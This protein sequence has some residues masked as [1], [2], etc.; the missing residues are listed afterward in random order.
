MIFTEGHNHVVQSLNG[1]YKVLRMPYACVFLCVCVYHVYVRVVGRYYIGSGN[2]S[3]V[4]YPLT[5]MMAVVEVYRGPIRI[6]GHS[7][8]RSLLL[9]DK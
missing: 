9:L 2:N 7:S 8:L 4:S 6:W 3:T 1:E 5:V